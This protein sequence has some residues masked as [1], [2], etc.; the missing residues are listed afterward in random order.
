MEILIDNQSQWGQ[1][2]NQLFVVRDKYQILAKNIVDRLNSAGIHISRR[3][4]KVPK[5]SQNYEL[6]N[7]ITTNSS[8]VDEE[9]EY[10]N[11]DLSDESDEFEQMENTR[12]ICDEIHWNV[13]IN[14]NNS[15]T[16]ILTKYNMSNKIVCSLSEI[17]PHT[18]YPH[19]CEYGLSFESCMK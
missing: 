15:T 7:T 3:A 13:L 10:D 2:K 1:I 5:S 4:R 6:N 19:V 12:G 11:L 14:D 17:E 16:F 18:K 9:Y 8:I